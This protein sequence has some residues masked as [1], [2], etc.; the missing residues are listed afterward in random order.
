MNSTM[1][2]TKKL[3]YSALFAA[4]ATAVMFIEFPLPF[5]P[6]FLKVDLSGVVSLLAAF[7]FGPVSAVMITLVKDI[8]HFF[9]SGTGG[10]GELADFLMIS[11][12]SVIASLAY[13]RMH[14]RKGAV[15]GLSL[16]T[17]SMVIIGMLTNKYMLIPFFS[18]VMPLEAI[19]S[20]C[21]EINPLIGDLNT[22]IIF[23]AGPFNLIKGII[24]SLVTLL[25]YKRLS[26]FIKSNTIR[27]QR[28]PAKKVE[29]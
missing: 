20:T 6:P 13:R 8:I 10:V 17:A 29:A 25:L 12:F 19:F 4:I 27:D 1:T 21:A 23:G 3:T 11:T 9:S 15:I 24:L 28:A 2:H 18:N 16:G 26:V 5:M 22:Y 14:T 7:M